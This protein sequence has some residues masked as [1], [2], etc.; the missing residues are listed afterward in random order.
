[1]SF[2]IYPIRFTRKSWHIGLYSLHNCAHRCN[3]NVVRDKKNKK[4]IIK[5]KNTSNGDNV[6][7]KKN[8]IENTIIS[9]NN[10][11]INNPKGLFGNKLY[12]ANQIVIPRKEF[13]IILDFP[14]KKKLKIKI[15]EPLGEGFT[16]KEVLYAIQ[17]SY[18]NIYRVEEETSTRQ[19]YLIIANC[20]ECKTINLK[21]TL[22]PVLNNE[23][24]N[25]ERTNNERSNN[26]ENICCICQDK[27]DYNQNIVKTNNCIHEFHKECMEDWITNGGKNCPICRKNIKNCDTCKGYGYH[28]IF[29]EGSV[30]PIEYR[31][32]EPRISTDGV[33][34]IYD[35]YLED[36]YIH[37]LKFNN[38]TGELN[39][40]I[41]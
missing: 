37:L 28:T 33:Y 2:R 12:L 36:L 18:K 41:H 20:D 3:Y 11:D 16:L 25:N 23:R 8:Q 21:K 22:V 19:Q 4:F 13:Y 9:I 39:V 7:N 34:G 5:E 32:N 38:L 27:I 31:N 10:Y 6:C 1:M 15:T 29:Y 14:I 24:S 30:L 40:Y 26:E 17:I 35:Y